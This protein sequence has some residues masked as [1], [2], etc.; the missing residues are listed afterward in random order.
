MK[1]QTLQTATVSA[2]V[3]LT[4]QDAAGGTTLIYAVKGS[5]LTA[6]LQQIVDSGVDLDAMYGK[7]TTA[8][9]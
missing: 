9:M 4:D 2:G 8:L 7:G 1:S 5:Q 3:K 6:R